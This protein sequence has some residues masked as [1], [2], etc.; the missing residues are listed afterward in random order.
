MRKTILVY[1]VTLF[2]AFT[3]AIAKK[4]KSHKHVKDNVKHAKAKANKG[5]FNESHPVFGSGKLHPVHD[6]KVIGKFKNADKVKKEIEEIEEMEAEDLSK[7][8]TEIEDEMK[9][10][11]AEI[12]KLRKEKLEKILSQKEDLLKMKTTLEEPADNPV[13]GMMDK[14]GLMLNDFQL[15]Q[16]ERQEIQT[17][18][19]L[20]NNNERIEQIKL[21]QSYIQTLQNQ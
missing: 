9:E 4:E 8:L 12:I 18:E 10:K 20:S 15:D 5:V 16:V 3:P 1:L 17:N 6:D 21:L 2:M 7:E 11:Q 19:K 13:S 14:L